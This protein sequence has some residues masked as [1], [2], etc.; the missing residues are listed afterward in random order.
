MQRRAKGLQKAHTRESDEQCTVGS[1]FMSFGAD[2]AFVRG[3]LEDLSLIRRAF[4]YGSAHAGKWLAKGPWFVSL[5]IAPDA[6]A[7]CLCCIGGPDLIAQRGLR[8][9]NLMQSAVLPA[10]RA[11]EDPTLQKA[12]R[13]CTHTHTETHRQTQTQ[14]QRHTQRQR[15]TQTDTGLELL[16][17]R[18]PPGN[19]HLRSRLR[20]GNCASPR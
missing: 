2:V 18:H 16:H 17:L 7:C 6:P 12:G 19:C 1:L 11:A 8:G 15:Q 4:A 20:G 3:R 13:L 10:S 14:T 9:S 5:R